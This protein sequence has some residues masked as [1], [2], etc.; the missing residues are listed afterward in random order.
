MACN[1]NI[2]ELKILPQNKIDSW[3]K[4][5][6]RLKIATIATDFEHKVNIEDSEQKAAET[7]KRTRAAL[8]NAIGEKE[9]EIFLRIRHWSGCIRYAAL[10]TKFEE[11]FRGTE[12]KTILRHRLFNSRQK[13]EEE[14]LDFSKRMKGL[15]SQCQ[16]ADLKSDITVQ[17]ILKRLKMISCGSHCY[18]KQI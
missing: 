18:R 14:Q 3:P 10:V 13:P 5:I 12:N 2:P 4:F 8:L 15:S 1:I 7:E 16:L 17:T 11:Y 9:I 6:K